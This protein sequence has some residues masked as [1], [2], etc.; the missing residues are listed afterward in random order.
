MFIKSFEAEN[1]PAAQVR[2][3]LPLSGVGSYKTT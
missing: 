1:G 3:I 2:M